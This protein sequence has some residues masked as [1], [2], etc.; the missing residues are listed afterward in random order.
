MSERCARCNREV[1]DHG[2]RCPSCGR[3]FCADCAA[4]DPEMA[5]TGCADCR[6]AR[7]EADR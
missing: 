6:T 1:G 2:W 7:A 4:A 5:D 3:E